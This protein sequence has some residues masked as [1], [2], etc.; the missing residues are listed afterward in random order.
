LHSPSL[1]YSL[2]PNASF[3]RRAGAPTLHRTI[4][5]LAPRR[6][7]A[8]SGARS[9]LALDS[10]PTRRS[11]LDKLLLLLSIQSKMPMVVY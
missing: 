2:L 9:Y 11:A 4:S 5:A 10:T 7:W 3:A 1:G 6:A 8:A